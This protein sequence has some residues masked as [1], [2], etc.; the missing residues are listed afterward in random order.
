MRQSMLWTF[1]SMSICVL[2]FF[3]GTVQFEGMQ[4]ATFQMIGFGG[5]VFAL[6][7]GLLLSQHASGKEQ[8]NQE[9]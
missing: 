2:L 1:I 5:M 6:L 7:Y 8:E 9:E 3:M 4:S